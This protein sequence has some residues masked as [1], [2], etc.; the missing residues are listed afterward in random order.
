MKNAKLVLV[1]LGFFF[2]ISCGAGLADVKTGMTEDEVKELLGDPNQ[3]N[4]S[5][6]STT[7]NG[8]TISHE[9]STWKYDGVGTIEFE[10][11]KVVDTHE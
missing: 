6:N 4:S 9:V 8:E 11:G 3:W 7:A 2:L 5:S 10:D 1:S